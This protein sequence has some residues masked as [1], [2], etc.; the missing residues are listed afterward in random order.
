LD[1]FH[2]LEAF[3]MTS[4]LIAA[5]PPNPPH[6]TFTS[7]IDPEHDDLVPVRQLAKQR[8]GKTISPSCLWRW[9]RKGVRGCRLEA[10]QVMGVWHTT[11]AA[12]GAFIAGQTAAAMAGD[13]DPATP[14]PRTAEKE[15]RLRA[16]GLL[17]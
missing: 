2:T 11:P 13:R 6:T 12:F 8:L 14:A 17:K 10:V 1:N 7:L 16:A 5:P 4:N 9:L 3:F 15:A